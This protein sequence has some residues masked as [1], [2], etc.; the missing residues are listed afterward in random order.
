MVLP[1]AAYRKRAHD[2]ILNIGLAVVMGF[3][4]LNPSY[5]MCIALTPSEPPLHPSAEG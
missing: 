4:E 2:P 1:K 3:A 5:A